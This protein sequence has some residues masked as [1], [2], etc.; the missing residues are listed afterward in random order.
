MR[1]VTF[2]LI[3]ANRMYGSVVDE[4]ALAT[5]DAAPH[6]ASMREA[7]RATRRVARRPRQRA[8]SMYTSRHHPPP[9][10]P[11]GQVNIR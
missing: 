2:E 7:A 6:P 3:G 10:S 1:Y 4:E 5:P 8:D 11:Q 9:A